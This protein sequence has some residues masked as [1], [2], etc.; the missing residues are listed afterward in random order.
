MSSPAEAR[1]LHPFAPGS[2]HDPCQQR[3]RRGTASL[4]GRHTSPLSVAAREESAGKTI[5]VI[6]ADTAE[7][8]VT[9]DLFAARQ[10]NAAH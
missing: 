2:G 5:V 3:G 7:R 6:L 1:P 9:T 8:Y 4:S 10:N